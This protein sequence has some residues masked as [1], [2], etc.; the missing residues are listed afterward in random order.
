MD[1]KWLKLHNLFLKDTYAKQNIGIASYFYSDLSLLF[2]FQWNPRAA[3]PILALYF[4]SHHL[5]D[6]ALFAP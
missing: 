5:D 6:P 3:I 2:L 1:I 4:Y